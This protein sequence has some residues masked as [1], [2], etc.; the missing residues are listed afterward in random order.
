MKYKINVVLVFLLVIS[1]IAVAGLTIEKQ[2]LEYIVTAKEEELTKFRAEAM[3]ISNK[4]YTVTNRVADLA[5][6]GQKTINKS[7]DCALRAKKVFLDNKDTKYTYSS[8][9]SHWN[10]LDKACYMQ[11]NLQEKLESGV[12]VPAGFGVFDLT[13]NKE[14]I[15]CFILSELKDN[16]TM[17]TCQDSLLKAQDYMSN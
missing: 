1:W 17:K 13:N 5:S 4:L 9:S 14:K 7:E 6:A 16:T 3:D 10:I 15:S 8:Y 12:V 2:K 11:I